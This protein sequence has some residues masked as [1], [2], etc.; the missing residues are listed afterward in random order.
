MVARAV[1]QALGN[2]RRVP[3]YIPFMGG[4]DTVTP[5]LQIERGFARAARNF[6]CSIN[7][8]YT[9]FQG[10]ER[11][12]GQAA[13]SDAQ[14]AVLDVTITGAFAV[15]DTITGASSGATA[16]VLAVVTSGTPDYLVITKIVGTFTNPETL[17]VSGNPQGTTSSVATVNGAA[18][19][20]LHAQY[21]NLAADEYRDD[22]AA[23]PGSGPVRGVWM[24]GANNTVYAFR[25]NAGGTATAL[26]K[27]S[28]SG[29][30]AVALGRQLSFT[31]GGTTAIAE[32]D[33]I[34]GAISGATAVVTRVVVTSGTWAGGDAAGKFVFA[35]QTG[36]FQAENIDVG[37]SPNLATIAGDSSAITL[38]PDGRYEFI[39]ANFGGSPNAK[40][41]YGCDG[42]NKGFEF[43]GTVYVPIDTGMTLDQP[44]HI[45]AHK[46]HLFFS[47][48]GSLQHS[49][50]TVITGTTERFGPYNWSVV[51]GA[52]ELAMGDTITGLL[53]QPGGEATAALGVFSRNQL[54]MLYG[55]SSADWELNTYKQEAGAY[56][57]SIQNLGETMFLDDRGVTTLSTS[58]AFGNFADATLSRRIQDWVTERR[59][60]IDAS[61]IARDK[62]QYRLFFTDGSALFI[63]MYNRKLVGMMPM[64]FLDNV[65]CCCSLEKA[66]GS[67]AIYFGSDD[68]FVY[69][70]EKGT[71]MD[72]D[73]LEHYLYLVF[74][75][76][77]GPRTIKSYRNGM[78]E[79]EGQG[80]A[81]MQI[82]ADL[83]YG[84]A[85]VIQQDSQ[86]A[87]MGFDASFWDAGS[88]D[89]G[90]WDGVTL[91]PSEFDLCGDA[92]N[93]SLK[94]YG[95]SD[96]FAP[97]T[98]SGA[99]INM[100]PR[101]LMR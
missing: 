9:R 100:I 43:D 38:L 56:E 30:T 20:V 32:G 70:M 24:Y 8:G 71:S 92:E 18:T 68:G 23:V 66:D 97:I 89:V 74:N 40:R 49:G 5:P 58:A 26:Y 16:V 96:Y 94:I 61:C 99:I 45:A 10:Y 54:A 27:S 46:N 78:L 13:P 76:S 48:G 79:V 83:G 81:E 63:T 73:D 98:L 37:A 2:V 36:T 90:V 72:G 60:T 17:N 62:N 47:F 33:T 85:N 42:V 1:A 39:T 67:E 91:M 82:S 6:E 19:G 88:W 44:K 77:G 12:D 29:W 41:I 55:T 87:V 95:N 57:W 64:F 101:R 51:V 93:C 35:S 59:T 84:S 75:H 3:D 28:S 11:F 4:L 7:G 22:I 52:A 53:S 21:N 80:Y 86:S 50:L 25:N 14:Y 69:Q 65:E 34:T 15:G 31:S